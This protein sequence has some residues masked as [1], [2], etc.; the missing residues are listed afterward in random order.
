MSI[1]PGNTLPFIDRY[2]LYWKDSSLKIA[3]NFLLHGIPEGKTILTH[4]HSQTVISLLGQLQKQQIPF[5]IL[6]T[7]SSPGEEG[8]ISLKR[9]HQ[10]KIKARLVNDSEIHEALLQTDLI[11]M[12]C[13]ALLSMEFLN[14]IGTRTILEHAKELQL[15]SFMVT[16]S[17]KEI[18]LENWN[19]PVDHPL[20]EWVSLDLI[21]RI[22]SEKS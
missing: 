5:R 18:S 11:L 7:C 20:F 15:P 21:D 1:F 6:Q 16:E 8:K 17:R 2:R 3:A 4:S 9:M 13:D 10:Q 19:K 12:G 22:V 14:K